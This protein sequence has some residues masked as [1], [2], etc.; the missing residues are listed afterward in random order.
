MWYSTAVVPNSREWKLGTREETEIEDG[1]TLAGN[2]SK[3]LSSACQSV[4][5]ALLTTATTVCKDV[6]FT[7]H[8]PP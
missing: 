4:L 3:R 7:E 5:L 8:S 1:K 6:L 2:S